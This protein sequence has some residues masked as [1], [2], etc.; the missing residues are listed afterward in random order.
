MLARLLLAA[1]E[2]AKLR[3]QVLFLL[4]LPPAQRES[5]VNSALAEMALRG[6]PAGKPLS[7][8]PGLAE[9][10]HHK[11]LVS[12]PVLDEHIQI[13]TPQLGPVGGRIVAETFLGL[14]FAATSLIG[15]IW[16]P[17]SLDRDSSL[18]ATFTVLPITVKSTDSPYPIRPSSR[19]PASSPIPSKASSLCC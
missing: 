9:A 12:I 14:M 16:T 5:L 11:K 2:D 18:L 1:R 4:K 6:E 3:A 7:A 8:V 15:R 17:F 10:A 19:G 13:E